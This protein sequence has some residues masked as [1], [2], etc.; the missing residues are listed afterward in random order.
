MGR[1]GEGHVYIAD[2]GPWAGA[3]DVLEFVFVFVI[4]GEFRELFAGDFE[5]GDVVDFFRGDSLFGGG[6]D[7][8]F[9]VGEGD[10]GCAELNGFEGDVLGYI[11]RTRDGHL[12]AR[13]RFF[14]TRGILDHMLN[15]LS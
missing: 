4:R 1:G 8:A 14:A 10:D 2:D 3:V 15:V 7:G 6:D 12:F 11:A 5:R 13:E 9:A